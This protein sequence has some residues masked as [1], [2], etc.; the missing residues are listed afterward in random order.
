MPKKLLAVILSAFLVL[1][2][3]TSCS[4][5]SNVINKVQGNDIATLGDEGI[6]VSGLPI[7]S[8]RYVII[9]D[10]KPTSNA[11]AGQIYYVDLY[12]K[13]TFRATDTVTFTQPEINVQTDISLTYSATGDEYSAYSGQKL[14]NVFSIKVR[15]PVTGSNQAII[16]TDKPATL[17]ILSPNGGEVYHVGETV[18]ITWT[19]T[20]LSKNANINIDLSY[21]SA[22]H[23]SEVPIADNVPNTG[24]YKWTVSSMIVTSQLKIS[25]ETNGV[26]SNGGLALISL[27][28][29]YFAIT[30]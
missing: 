9:V 2:S 30:N 28:A 8:S 29:N 5:V 12:E 23:T 27:S 25:L 18:D 6:Y 17:K 10:L 19:S 11:I 16:N 26:A 3:L 21:Q 22:N 1:V 13:G 24:S 14:S 15:E 7:Y 20:N 4:A